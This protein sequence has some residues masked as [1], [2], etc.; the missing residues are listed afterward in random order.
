MTAEVYDLNLFR[1]RIDPSRKLG[2]LA[3]VEAELRRIGPT[4]S[5]EALELT[6]LKHQSKSLTEYLLALPDRP[7]DTSTEWHLVA[8]LKRIKRLRKTDLTT[9]IVGYILWTDQPA[10]ALRA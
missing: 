6:G 4:L 8:E 3:F 9:Y 10:G 7:N 5:K 2:L 1:E